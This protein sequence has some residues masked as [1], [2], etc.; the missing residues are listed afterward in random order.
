LTAIM[1]A[2]KRCRDRLRALRA[3]AWI[4]RGGAMNRAIA[5]WLVCL[6]DP[7]GV[8]RPWPRA[9]LDTAQF[10]ALCRQAEAHGVL[11]L[12]LGNGGDPF[13]IPQFRVPWHAAA[14]RR[15]A[16]HGFTLM[17]RQRV[18][19]L[20]A[21]G[22][23]AGLRATVV[24]GMT[25][26]DRI[27]PD[28]AQRRFTDIDIL[29]DPAD[30]GQ[31]ERALARLGYVREPVPSQKL[32][33]RN[34]V[35][36]RRDDIVI[37]LQTDLVHSNAVRRGISLDYSALAAGGPTRPAALLF[38]ALVHGAMHQFERLIQLVD[39]LQATRA[40]E[41]EADFIALVDQCGAQFVAESALMLVGDVFAEARCHALAARFDAVRYAGLARWLMPRG[42]LLTDVERPAF[43][44]KWRRRIYRELLKLPAPAT[45]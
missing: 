22:E 11:A 15:A 5:D 37:D 9:A 33:C 36:A 8:R 29:I 44:V 17:L 38:V 10:A 42:R 6:S 31:A 3:G 12:V 7:A 21:D 24:K 13:D 2:S 32:E 26:A 35:D 39:V 45:D 4:P 20:M 34:W 25:F 40:L 19:A 1:S 23:F 43:N 27:Y 18:R 28:R 14:S 41:D 16:M 30:I